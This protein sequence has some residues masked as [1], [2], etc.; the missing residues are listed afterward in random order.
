MDL[1]IHGNLRKRSD[2]LNAASS[3]D[4]QAL[5]AA[6]GDLKDYGTGW[7]TKSGSVTIPS[8]ARTELSLP[9]LSHWH[10]MGSPRLGVALLVG[11]RRKPL[12]TLEF[13]LSVDEEA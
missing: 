11:P 2:G 3:S 7:A 12:D 1:R 13:L 8:Q 9:A 10:V 4:V 6:L 5:V